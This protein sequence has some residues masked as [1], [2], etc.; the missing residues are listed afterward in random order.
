MGNDGVNGIANVKKVSGKTYAQDEQS[1][2]VYGMSKIAIN[3]SSINH[4]FPAHELAQCING[5]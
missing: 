4:I 5:I 1:S 2:D 3:N